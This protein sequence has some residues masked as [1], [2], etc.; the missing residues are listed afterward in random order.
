MCYMRPL[1]NTDIRFPHSR[2]DRMHAHTKFNRFIVSGVD[3][4]KIHMHNET[5]I[6]KQ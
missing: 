2:K 6:S 4:I 1:F 3:A 5:D